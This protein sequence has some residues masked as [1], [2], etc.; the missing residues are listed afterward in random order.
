MKF[1]V[2]G[3]ER[4]IDVSRLTIAGWTGRDQAAQQAHIEE[5]QALGIEPPQSTPVY[6]HVGKE[7]LTQD[8]SIDVVGGNSSGEAEVFLL[9]LDDGIYLGV[10]SDHTDRELEAMDITL[11]K[12]NCPKPVSRELWRL[13]DVVEHWDEIT[14]RSYIVINSERTLYQQASIAALLEPREI[15]EKA[16]LDF[17]NLNTGHAIF[18]GT[19]SVIGGIRYGEE[20]QVELVDPVKQRKLSHAYRV[21]DVNHVRVADHIGSQAQV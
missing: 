2:D 12:Q 20:Y 17:D 3:M 10:G 5:L 6:Y 14:L 21:R 9:A 7:L 16:A 8:G 1:I 19:V 11:S 13:S 4:S 18:C 15:V